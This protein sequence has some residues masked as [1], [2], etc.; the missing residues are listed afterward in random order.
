MRLLVDHQLP[1]RLAAH[2]RGW[3]LNCVH[4]SEIG[5]E[6]EDDRTIWAW[7]CSEERTLVSKDEDF[8]ALAGGVPSGRGLIWVRLGNCRN[9]ALLAAF[10]RVRD[11][12]L[13]MLRSGHRVIEI[14]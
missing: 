9:D 3:G 1:V 4:V 5:L 7:A 8:L 6:R 13:G 12:L 10:D 2:L 14:W 11:E